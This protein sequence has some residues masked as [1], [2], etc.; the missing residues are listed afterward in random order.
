[1]SC[2]IPLTWPFGG[3]T[4]TNDKVNSLPNRD[5][6]ENIH[7]DYARG[8]GRWQLNGDIFYGGD[9]QRSRTED[10]IS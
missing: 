10:I 9:S 7:K 8:S 1:M 3:S 6:H 4:F 2:G 5:V